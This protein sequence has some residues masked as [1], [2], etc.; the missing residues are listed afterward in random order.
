MSITIQPLAPDD[1]DAF[2][3][4]WQG[5]LT[6]YKSS[7]SVDQ[8]QLTWARLQ[9][10][11]QP[12]HGLGAYDAGNL[13]GFTIYL[14]HL[15]SWAPTSYCYL[16][17]LFT[18]ESA[19]GN[20]VAAA[21]IEAVARDAKARGATKLYWQTQSTNQRARALYDRVAANEGFIVYARTLPGI[22]RPPSAPD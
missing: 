3:P 4:L 16:E 18:A 9:D 7:L 20:G 21:L 2:L 11:S 22:E 14:F 5:Y 19:R 13:V 6:F 8:T 1:F 10:P 15:S 17:D 12:M